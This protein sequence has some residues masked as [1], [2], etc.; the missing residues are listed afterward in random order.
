M[1]PVDSETFQPAENDF[2]GAESLT[3]QRSMD[4]FAKRSDA[5]ELPKI[6]R[7]EGIYLW[8]ERGNRFIDASSGPVVSNIGHGR[9][10]VAK[11]LYRQAKTV[12]FAYPRVARHQPNI[13]LATRLSELAGPG[14]ERVYFSSGGSEAVETAIKF[15][16]QLAVANGDATRTEVVSCMPSYHGGT[17]GALSVSGDLMQSDFT[18]GFIKT[19]L[20]VP[21]PFSYRVPDGLSAEDYANRCCD[22]LESTI[23]EAGPKNV[24]AFI[25][26]PVGGLAT[27]CNTPP[28]SYFNRVREITSRF[29]IFL[30]YDEVLCGMGRTGTFLASH[31]FPKAQADVVVLAKGL[32]AGYS[33][34][35]ATLFSAQMVNTLAA[36][37]G[38]NLMHTY[39]ANP[40]S[41]AAGLAVLDIYEAEGLLER[42]Q[43][44]GKYLRQ[45]LEKLKSASIIVGDIRGDGLLY[46]VELVANRASKCR[47]P[48]TSNPGNDVRNAGLE[49]GLLI[50]ARRT[51]GGVFG[52]WFMISPPLTITR[53][54]VDD[55]IARLAMT[56]KTTA[57]NLRHNKD[58]D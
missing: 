37:T 28:V 4:V 46:A 41:C 57:R 39:A 45:E 51:S 17:M 14:Y 29:G 1:K 13:E 19:S 47:F 31:K 56:L 33:P 44:I 34:L 18:D 40:I 38:F 42:V 58:Q 20:K 5:Y 22:E 6:V 25:I 52:D 27:G 3:S 7:G 24:L 21:A 54:E 49:N 55:L 30:I 12:D 26:E 32:A 23:L 36:K 50:Y 35:G 53:D 43:D 2:E 10:E 9:E 15:L 48:S 16:R 11:A 8:D